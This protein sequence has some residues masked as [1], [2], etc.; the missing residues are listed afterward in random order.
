MVCTKCGTELIQGAAFCHMCG[1]AADWQP[2][3]RRRGNGEGTAIKRG[4]TW[5]AVISGVGYDPQGKIIRTRSWKGGFRTKHEALAWAAQQSGKAVERPVP[6]FVDLWDSYYK[7]DYRKLSASK[8]TA[9]RIAWQRLSAL[10]GRTVD[11]VSVADLQDVIDAQ[12]SSYYTARD[13]KQVLSHLY[14]RAMADNGPT[15]HVTQNL[16]R[17]I[18]L[19]DLEEQ[20][21]TPFTAGEV[22]RIWDLYGTG[23]LTA[24][25]ILV[26]LYTGMMPAEL[27]MCTSAMVDLERRE[28]RGAGTKTSVRKMAAVVF[29]EFLSPVLEDL[30]TRSNTG[31]LVETSKWPFYAA[32]YEALERAGID[33]P[34][35][36][37]GRHRLTPYSCRHTYGTEA[38]RLG[39]HPALVQQLLRH[40]ST[41]TQEKYTHLA[42]ADVHAAAESFKKE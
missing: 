39:L 31:K 21:G 41:K 35:D 9:Y 37:K 3:K 34:T 33:N 17:H 23:D 11:S 13:C 1:R 29:P 2:S 10:M 32:F 40:S 22:Q 28:I 12:C 27:L 4:K 19:P 16:A 7:T 38:V 25:R 20:E 14:E 6:R 26:M 42:S 24:A 15:G 30:M 36:A 18:A 5:T 8:Q